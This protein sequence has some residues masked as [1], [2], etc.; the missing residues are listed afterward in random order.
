MLRSMCSL[1]SAVSISFSL[2]LSPS[3]SFWWQCSK[4]LADTGVA[5]RPC[6]GQ[7]QNCFCEQIP[8]ARN[9]P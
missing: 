7:N 4:G 2:H 1:C 6:W 9:P 5:P 3:L 8:L